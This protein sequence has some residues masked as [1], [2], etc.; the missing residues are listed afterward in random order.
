[1]SYRVLEHLAPVWITGAL[2]ISFALT[3]CHSS[4]I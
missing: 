4:P 1:M 2:W 3:N